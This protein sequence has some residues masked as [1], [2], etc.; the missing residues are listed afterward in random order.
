MASV[1]AAIADAVVTELNAQTWVESFTA[2]RRNLLDLEHHTD[3]DSLTVVVVPRIRERQVEDRSTNRITYTVD[4]GVLQRID[5][6]T[7]T[8][9]NTAT[10]PLFEL[11]EDI[12]DHFDG[13]LPGYSTAW[14]AGSEF[15]VDLAELQERHRFVGVLSLSFRVLSAR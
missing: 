4:V 7:A 5:A 9:A 8:T 12:D 2:V 3:L 14:S 6:A 10:D 15:L 11:V 13:Q 1:I